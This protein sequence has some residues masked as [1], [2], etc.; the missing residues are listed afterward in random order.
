MAWLATCPLCLFTCEAGDDAPL[1]RCTPAEP[2]PLALAA[3]R[4]LDE[5]GGEGGNAPGHGHDIPGVWNDKTR[6]R[7][8]RCD[9]LGDLRDALARKEPS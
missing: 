8:S 3:Q 7:C 9:A 2:V 6:G 1:H 5:L 4:F